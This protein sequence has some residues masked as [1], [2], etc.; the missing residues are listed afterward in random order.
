MCQFIIGDALCIIFRMCLNLG[1]FFIQTQRHFAYGISKIFICRTKR[2]FQMRW[3]IVHRAA[4]I[5]W[6]AINGSA[7]IIQNEIAFGC[8]EKWLHKFINHSLNCSRIREKTL[9]FFFMKFQ[10]ANHPGIADELFI[11]SF[12]DLNHCRT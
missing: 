12:A 11:A 1:D 7:H 8:H 10:I 9:P 3:S 5:Q 2:L 6:M 4:P